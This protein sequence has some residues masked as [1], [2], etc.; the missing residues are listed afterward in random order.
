MQEFEN[1]KKFTHFKIHT[2]YSICEGALKIDDLNTYCKENKI[3]SLG[4]SDTSN[5]CGAL[6]FSE[7]IVKSGTQP[8]IGTQIIFKFED[9]EGL[10]T[11]I[12]KNEQGYRNMIELSSKS[13]LENDNLSKP[14]CKLSDLFEKNKGLIVMSGTINGLIGNLFN[15]GKFELIEDIYKKLK[16]YYSDNFYIEIQRHSD[17]DEK[18]FEKFN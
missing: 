2:Q 13:Y 15:K 4:I 18:S 10:L 17:K 5:L 3:L 1:P 8:I 12:A 14:H 9:Q 7:K 16:N 11:L 6:E